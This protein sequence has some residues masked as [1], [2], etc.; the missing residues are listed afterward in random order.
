MTVSLRAFVCLA[1]LISFPPQSAFAA[2]YTKAKT[3]PLAVLKNEGYYCAVK[4]K[5]SV[6]EGT[7]PAGAIRNAESRGYMPV[8]QY[9][10]VATES[11]IEPITLVPGQEFSYDFSAKARQSPGKRVFSRV[12]DLPKGS[13]HLSLSCQSTGGAR[14]SSLEGGI[15][16]FDMGFYEPGAVFINNHQS[17]ESYS[18]E[19]DFSLDEALE[20]GRLRVVIDRCV[21]GSIILKRNT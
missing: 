12:I 4:D 9:C 8:E 19:K 6:I 5:D 21:K 14:I 13:Y 20:N 1:I 11:I 16:V 15:E 18:G 2:R 7:N 10:G 3:R 17:Q